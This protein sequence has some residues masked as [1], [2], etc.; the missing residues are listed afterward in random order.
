M[1]RRSCA[2]R[3][4]LDLVASR[5]L[6]GSDRAERWASVATEPRS[7]YAIEV[8]PG[9]IGKKAVQCEYTMAAI[10]ERTE[11]EEQKQF[12]TRSGGLPNDVNS[13]SEGQTCLS[14]Q[15]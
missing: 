3:H 7:T 6:V 13:K 9:S 15:H 5:S 4:C 14:R 8:I 1:D 10:T 12:C 2:P 11:S